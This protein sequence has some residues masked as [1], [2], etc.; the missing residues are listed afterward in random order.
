[1]KK[2]P[3][4][5]KLQIIKQGNLV[6]VYSHVLDICTTGKS[7]EQARGNFDTLVSIFL[8]DAEGDIDKAGLLHQSL[9]NR[10]WTNRAKRWVP[11]VVK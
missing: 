10:G 3:T 6:I 1:M 9:T 4:D 7:E 5:F 11:P 8:K 2:I